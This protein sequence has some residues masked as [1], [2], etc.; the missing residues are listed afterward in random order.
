MKCSQTTAK[1]LEESK[2]FADS[3]FPQIQDWIRQGLAGLAGLAGA[4]KIHQSQLHGARMDEK[5]QPVRE[6]IPEAYD[7]QE[8]TDRLCTDVAR[9]LRKLS[10]HLDNVQEFHGGWRKTIEA[11]SKESQAVQ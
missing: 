6:K 1:Y 7:K 4:A 5:E 2:N 11:S 9:A 8:T 3:Q 10:D